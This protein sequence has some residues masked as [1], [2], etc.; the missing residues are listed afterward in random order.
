MT[1]RN[2]TAANL[3]A[4]SPA[5]IETTIEAIADVASS[6]PSIAP[7]ELTAIE[8]HAHDAQ[9]PIELPNVV[10]MRRAVDLPPAVAATLSAIDAMK[11]ANVAEQSQMSANPENDAGA[12]AE[13]PAPPRTHRF[14]FLAASVAFA[15]AVGAMAGALGAS[16]IAGPG[17]GVE[18]AVADL[19]AVQ[20]AIAKLQIEMASVRSSVESG[21][22]NANAQLTKFTERLD[23]VAQLAP[24]AQLKHAMDAIDR[25]EKRAQAAGDV[26]GSIRAQ[27]AATTPTADPQRSAIVDGWVV[28]HVNRGV[29]LI[30]GNRVGA[31][32]VEAGDVVPGVG[33]IESIRRQEGRWVVLTSRGI[34]P[35]PA[36][37][38]VLTPR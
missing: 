7:P 27:H 20:D 37:T 34:I 2:D 9:Q 30:E 8:A 21:N 23:R 31:I 33:R 26:T 12:M 1:L 28:R 19:S 6:A 4:S 24:A 14:V 3:A 35:S 11:T 22:R 5:Q 18:L 17:R 15:G 38:P 10:E 29:A 32:E 13:P 25:L 36:P 16:V